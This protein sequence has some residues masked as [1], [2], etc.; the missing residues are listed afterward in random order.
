MGKR[1]VVGVKECGCNVAAKPVP[2]TDAAML[3]GFLEKTDEP[4]PTFSTDGSSSY[5]KPREYT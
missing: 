2:S 1:G 5:R 4:G 3:S